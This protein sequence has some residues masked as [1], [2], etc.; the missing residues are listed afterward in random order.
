[1]WNRDDNSSQKPLQAPNNKGG[2][3]G[4]PAT[5]GSS[6]AVR[7][8]L[9]GREDL[10][11]DG[12]FEGSI[13]VAGCQVTIGAT[14]QI[15][16]V[17]KAKTIA[18]EGKV[19]GNL[20]ADDQVV[21]RAS[22]QMDGDIQAPRVA[23][24]EGCQFKGNIDMEPHAKKKAPEPKAEVKSE[25]KPEAKPEAPATE[26][27]QKSIGDDSGKEPAPATADSGKTTETDPKNESSQPSGNSQKRG[28][29][30]RHKRR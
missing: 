15:E 23:L 5:I 29:G 12:T 4:R 24:D 2:A 16:G 30:N 14:G 6:I 9:L 8:E 11:I 18:V 27:S 22:G 1:M 21:V 17:V 26:T 7:G 20:I 3:T 13:S 25:P 28:H 19:K 10:T